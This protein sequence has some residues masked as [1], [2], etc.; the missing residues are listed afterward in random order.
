MINTGSSFLSGA[1]YLK[2]ASVSM[3]LSDL[4]A[5]NYIDSILYANSS[6]PLFSLVLI[7]YNIPTIIEV[8]RTPKWVSAI[9][10]N[11]PIW[12]LMASFENDML[13]PVFI[14]RSVV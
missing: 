4:A 2:F 11:L 12:P 13:D 14:L 1:T 6:C 7:I 9:G 3:R 5:K 8:K 10:L